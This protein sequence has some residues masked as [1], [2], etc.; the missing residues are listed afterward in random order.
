MPRRGHGLTALTYGANS[1]PIANWIV[2][3]HKHLMVVAFE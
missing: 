3:S 1:V 2:L